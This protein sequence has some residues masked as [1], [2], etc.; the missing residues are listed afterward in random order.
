MILW[1]NTVEQATDDSSIWRMH[2]AGWIPKA[3][4]IYSE[5]VVRISFPQQQWLH[6]RV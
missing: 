2:I 4:D 1:K 6:E 3:T 5:Y